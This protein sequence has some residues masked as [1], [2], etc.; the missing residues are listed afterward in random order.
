MLGILFIAFG[1]FASL[2][3]AVADYRSYKR[4]LQHEGETEGQVVGW[5][6]HTGV[7]NNTT[8]RFPIIFFK[9]GGDAF[10]EIYPVNIAFRLKQVRR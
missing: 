10:K 3:G 5:D 1:G 2:F 9:C 6:I 7:M 8:Y 4:I